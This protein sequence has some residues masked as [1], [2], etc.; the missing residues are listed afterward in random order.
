MSTLAAKSAPPPSRVAPAAQRS[1]EPGRK[2]AL[3][4]MIGGL[5]ANAAGPSVSASLLQAKLQ[6]GRPGDKYENEPDQTADK[7]VAMQMPA[8]I[9]AGRTQNHAQVLSGLQR[10][11]A[12]SEK[13]IHKKTGKDE[14]LQK[15][16]QHGIKR[17]EQHEHHSVTHHA[18]HHAEHVQ[19]KEE[20]KLQKR[21]RQT[22]KEEK[23]QKAGNTDPEAL[24]PEFET[25]LQATLGGGTSLSAELRTYMEPRFGADFSNVKIHTDAVA[26]QLCNEAG[27]QAFAYTN[28]IYFNSGKYNPGTAEG[29][30]LIAHEL[31]HVIQQGAAPASRMLEGIS[32]AP[33]SVQRSWLSD[34]IN[35]ML[36]QIPGFSLL[37]VLLGRNPVTGENVPRT[38]VNIIRG[39]MGLLGPA[40]NA[41][42][43]RL[44][45][46]G[47]ITRASQWL[48]HELSTIADINFALFGSLISQAY[49]QVHI[50]NSL[51]ENIDIVIRVFA[52]T[53]NRLRTFASNVGRK[54]LEFIKEV[55]LPP[56]S[57]F[58]Q[59]IPGYYL[60]TVILARDPI[61]G[62]PVERSATNLVRGFMILV[63]GGEEKFNQLQQSGALQRAFNWLNEQVALLNLSWDAIVA[64][65][66]TAWD[67][68]SLADI[69]HPL[70]AFE[71]IVDLFR[72]PVGRIITFASN[73]LLKV[74]EF[75]FEG[76][77]GAAG[78]RI[79]SILKRARDTF[80]LVINDPVGF[81]SNLIAAVRQGIGQF[82]RNILRHLGRGVV[83]WLLGGLA[84][85]GIQL[86]ERWDLRGVLTLVL[87]IL[88]LTYARIRPK[89]VRLI[90]ERAVTILETTF[91]LVR[92]L[93]TQGPAA[94]WQKILEY[95]GN[96]QEMVMDRVK[97][98]V[99]RTI[100]VQAVMRLASLF[101]PIGALIQAIMGIYNTINF[102][103]QRI[104]Q[105]ADLV[106]SIVDSVANI[107]AG[108]IGDAANYVEQTMARAI[109][110]ILG[111]LAGLI[112]LGD[113]ATP[114]RE[115]IQRIQE[116]VDQA[117][118]RAIA[119]IVAQA[120]RL[121]AAGRSAVARVLQ[122]WRTRKTF[123][124]ANGENHAV[125]FSGSETN[126]EIMVASEEINL[127]TLL[128]AKDTEITALPRSN[129]S[130]GRKTTALATARTKYTEI[131]GLKRRIATASDAEKET[132]TNDLNSRFDDLSSALVV[133]GVG[134]RP[135]SNLPPTNI[136]T[137]I[138]KNGKAGKMV[139]DPLTK[140]GPRGSRP[141]AEPAGWAS[142]IKTIPEYDDYYVRL[143]ILSEKLHGSGAEILNLTPGR[144]TEN[145]LMEG[146][147]ETPAYNLIQQ[148]QVLWYESEVTGYR[149]E[150]GYTDF[151]E[152]IN[153]KYGI[154]EENDSGDWT[155]IGRIEYNNT[156]TVS[157]PDPRG[158]RNPIPTL[159][160]ISRD[161]ARRLDNV[162]VRQMERI[163]AGRR[164]GY[165][166]WVQ[167]EANATVR[168]EKA[169]DPNL[170]NNLKT[171]IPAK[172]T[173][174]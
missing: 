11:G 87:N 117:I 113:I 52:P 149:T 86:P 127:T 19:K 82:S 97:A 23:V 45:A 21:V 83:D 66:R 158:T 43:E 93:V 9:Q 100:V 133:I 29:K 108:R 58:A 51:R 123:R 57:Q 162:G 145:T 107:A 40:G 103:I 38:L 53:V 157:K 160:T 143:H 14:H 144:K 76:F 169:T 90:G 84:S 71:R 72:A 54:I 25:R 74:L 18:N 95:I 59:R 129:R 124:T 163:V 120:Q 69:P 154:S 119:W 79:L 37:C 7:V 99:Q 5:S 165:T 170:I 3:Q 168:A 49:D 142:H 4:R 161:D 6:V 106:E 91:E 96:I 8:A 148:N 156:F 126:P 47:A 16:E 125:Y 138:P 48:D 56:V 44:N 75:I 63:P 164:R 70:A 151:A 28:H 104:N 50:Y 110:V 12:P 111:F 80:R 116:A 134:V 112:G 94:A 32:G 114:I 137:P 77:M 73:V 68:L 141:T 55:I 174:F 65:F 27:A 85:A 101:N 22:Y 146:Q 171:N 128:N 139:A 39:F 33:K 105:I 102:F 167:F 81:L 30:K 121:L 147:A 131:G 140:L 153:I 60:L 31:T 166:T 173:D 152:G 62:T 92:I 135:D 67:S 109:P 88:G 136:H 98:W 155:R 118:D 26:I 122:W 172:L 150:V 10:S 130:K 2:P 34:H 36:N 132:I 61:A 17:E 35:E 24:S 41:L 159:N 13:S 1:S 115:T 42:F 20:N 64:L 78:T 46:S 89:I 15:K